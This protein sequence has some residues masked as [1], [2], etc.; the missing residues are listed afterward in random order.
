MQGA[1]AWA[2]YAE[3][4]VPKGIA[5]TAAALLYAGV[6]L[7]AIRLPSGKSKDSTPRESRGGGGGDAKRPDIHIHITGS[8]VRTEAERGVMA[9]A[10]IQ[11]ARRRGML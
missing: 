1:A 8:V 5:H 6:A 3:G 4:N 11:E 9:Q 7:K 2:A 10:A